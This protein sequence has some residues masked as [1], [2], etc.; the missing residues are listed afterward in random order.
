MKR[1]LA[2]AS[3]WLTSGLMVS[4]WAKPRIDQTL[5]CDVLIVGGGLSA[6]A[7]AYE[8]LLAG[9]NVCMTEITDWIGGQISSQAVS[10]LDEARHQRQLRYFSRGFNELRDR[11]E[12]FYG[13]L[14]PGQCWVSTAC[15]LPRDGN[16]LLQDQLWA[17]AKRGK[18][19]LFWLPNT[20]LK[21]LRY[22][23]DR[24]QVIGAIALQHTP[25]PGTPPLNSDFL[26]ETLIDSYQ[27]EDSKRFR[28]RMIQL[29]PSN[30]LVSPTPWYVIEATETGELLAL[31]DVPYRLG[32]DAR[33]W[34]NPSSPV[35]RPDPY[36]TQGFTY[37]FAMVKT[38]TAE[39]QV[40]PRF[41]RRFA[42]YYSYETP[43][44][45]NFERIFTYRR[46]WAPDTRPPFVKGLKIA[47]PRPGDISLQNWTWGNDYRPGSATDNLIL[48]REQLQHAGQ[49]QQGGWLGGLRVSTLQ[50]GEENSLG[51]YYWLV[52]G[53]T[54][55]RLGHDSKQPHPNQRF[56]KGFHSPL[57]TL[58]GLSKY[59]YIREARR[60]VGRPSL[61][62]PLGF[63]IDELDISQLGYNDSV[64]SQTLA[65]EDYQQL[66][67]YLAGLNLLKPL[68]ESIP[69][70]RLPRR[71]R[72]TVFPDSVGIA[73]YA[74]D[75]HP[76]MALS[77]PE[78]PGN[79]E[80]P[81]SRR[82]HGPA[83]PGEIPLRAMIP[84]QLDNLLVTGKAIA[85]SN[86]AAAA[87][88][89][90]PFEWS[91]GAAAGATADFALREHVLPYQLVDQLPRQ[92]P[93]LEKLQKHLVRNGNPIRFP[94]ASIFNESWE[95][96][97]VW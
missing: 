36:C 58:H 9:R 8:L 22:S 24:Q 44:P 49:L 21:E 11:L 18:G 12:R 7:A 73:Q 93:Q 91:V 86:I 52:A 70:D 59:P 37:P 5:H 64:Y 94:N 67:H 40:E 20:V 6:T 83:F 30:P 15:F 65:P 80:F 28:K 95:D 53:T 38:P 34:R 84:Q 1:F 90:H 45:N 87:Y 76:C 82:A 72:S 62:Y 31:T 56:L 51:F 14:N 57:G 10:A 77:P 17:A 85:L 39:R 42:P 97:R 23:P 25:Q 54:D 81:G 96:W 89:V 4:A 26:S 43:K 55:S 50:A 41:Y 48:T 2:V 29:L 78:V 63:S 60:L 19:R 75:F 66:R 68:A 92:E 35:E 13:R 16:K 46:I 88:R 74:L 32:L 61:G 47:I 71:Q 3:L 33:S 69:L 79:Q 27:Y